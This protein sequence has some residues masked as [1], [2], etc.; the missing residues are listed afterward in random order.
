MDGTFLTSWWWFSLLQ[1]RF[2]L[3][4]FSFVIILIQSSSNS[5]HLLRYSIFNKP[6]G[7]GGETLFISSRNAL[8]TVKVLVHLRHQESPNFPK[9]YWIII[10]IQ[11]VAIPFSKGSS[12]PRDQTRVSHTVDRFFTIWVTRCD[13]KGMPYMFTFTRAHMPDRY[14]TYWKNTFWINT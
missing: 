1:V 12:S 9:E 14:I 5:N 2:C 6:N 7:G 13:C 11:W 8:K 3:V 4:R 10:P